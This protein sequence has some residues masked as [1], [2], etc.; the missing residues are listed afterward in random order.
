MSQVGSAFVV[1]KPL[2]TD[3]RSEVAQGVNRAV[4]SATIPLP[5]SPKIATG[6]AVTW[7]RLASGATI[8]KVVPLP[9]QP[10]ITP[11][12]RAAF[13]AEVGGLRGGLLGSGQF[14]ASRA[15]GIGGVAAGLFVFAKGAVAAIKASASL[16]Q[17]LNVFQQVSGASADQ[18]KRVRE[19]ARKLGAD[20]SLP[21]VS[22]GDAAQTMTELAKAGL[23]V[24]DVLSG[25]RGTLQLAAAAQIDFASATELSAN[26]LNAF[27]LPG[28]QAVK[29]A[30]LLAGAANAA[31]G[32]ISD[33]GNA[34]TQSAAVAHQAGIS[35]DQTVTFLTEL[36]KAG[37][38]G[39]DA[40]TSLR[41][42]LLRLIAPTKEARDIFKALGIVVTDASG[43][44]RVDVFE[45]LRRSMLRLDPAT[46]NAALATIFG[47]DAIRAAAIFTR[48][49]ARGFDQLEQQVTRQGQAAE[50][51]AARTK[52]LSGSISGLVS[53]LQTFGTDVGTVVLPFLTAIVGEANK[54]VTGLDKVDTKLIQIGK[55]VGKIKIPG[56]GTFGGELADAFKKFGGD[57]ALAIPQV[58]TLKDLVV[59]VQRVSSGFKNKPII[60]AVTGAT[61]PGGSALNRLI[62]GSLADPELEKAMAAAGR[63]SGAAFVHAAGTEITKQERTVIDAAKK[64]VRDAQTALKTVVAE[65]ARAIE[66]SAVEAKQSLT[67]IGQGLADQVG[68]LLDTGALAQRIGDLSTIQDRLTRSR[69]AL[70][71]S[72]D[73]QQKAL[74]RVNLGRDLK[75]AED[76][77]RRA[78]EQLVGGAPSTAES[79]AGNARFL[80]PFKDR[81]R[82]AKSALSDF[83][84]Q[85]RV[86]KVT[87]RINTLGLKISGLG[88]KLD[89]QKARIQRTL[90]DIVA[91][92]NAGLL[93]GPQASARVAAILEKNVGAMSKAGDKQGFAFK[94][95]FAAQV[96]AL[97]AQIAA[98]LGGPQ[99]KKTGAEP[100]IVKPSDAVTAAAANTAAARRSLGDALAGVAKAQAEATKA[101]TNPNG[102]NAILRDIRRELRGSPSKSS[103]DVATPGKPRVKAGGP[104]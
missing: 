88:D 97:Q 58:Q 98:I 96:F 72:L 10:T 33:F 50:T 56:G 85:A 3:F 52:G 16:E 7:E 94:Q 89:A 41:V 74:Q 8:P 30:D 18:M 90:N 49:G 81:V 55:D 86:D 2:L 95:A 102:T 1:V 19:E 27:Q 71:A 91:K 36:A 29:V 76:D 42:A 78:Q 24:N 23:S 69:D 31:Q 11:A 46:K 14:A 44:V 9:V 70:Q 21:A 22:A 48:E 17:E 43:N 77:L 57:A 25:T 101:I 68:T 92:F 84:A 62:T 100:T 67:S 38:S 61:P 12:A 51:A 40:G 53:N 83:D 64:T 20:I 66:A 59:A 5:V 32:N 65:G 37:I 60:P 4:G 39:S 15:L 54:A 82:D 34:L 87:E 73:R 80:Q 47:T 45:Q 79:R 63:K 28:A 6:S 13:G 93:T 104:R 99:T 75:T 26:A 103:A 35:I